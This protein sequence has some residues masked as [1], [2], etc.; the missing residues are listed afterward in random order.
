MPYYALTIRAD[1]AKIINFNNIHVDKQNNN[2]YFTV[3]DASNCKIQL[4][5]F[6]NSG[7]FSCNLSFNE[8]NFSIKTDKTNYFDNDTIK[9][10]ITPDNLPVNLTYANKTITAKNYTEFKSILYEDK[11]YAKVNDQ[12]EAVLINVNR[13]AD[14][15]T[16]WELCALFFIGYICYRVIKV[17]A[18]KIMEAK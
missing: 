2:F 16:L 7:I 4:N 8:I 10:Y 1:P 18:F 3:A 15:N 14:F 9:I 13:K 17:Y 12:E 5:D 6:F 11:I